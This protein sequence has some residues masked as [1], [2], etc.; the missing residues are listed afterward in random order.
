MNL[1][2]PLE[3]LNLQETSEDKVLTFE[4]S[5]FDDYLGQHEI[6][7]KLKVYTKAC[8]DRSDTLDHVLLFGPPGLGKTTLAKV[9]AKELSVSFKITSAPILERSG[10][11]VA[12]LS[13]L[14]AKEVLFID[15]IHR[16]PKNVEEILYSAMEN[17]C[18]DMIIGQGAGAKSIRLP[19]QPFT[20]IG[21]TTKTSLISG[22]LQTRFGI[23][24]RLDFYE[25]ED[26]AQIVIQNANFFKIPILPEAALSIGR[27][28]RGTPRIVKR[29]LRRV[30]DFAQVHNHKIIDNQIVDL[31][32][33]FLGIDED[34]LNK[35][36]RQILTHIIK[37]FDGGP[38]GVETLAALTGEDKETLEDV[39]EPF[40][41]RQGLL[42]K[43]SRGRQISPKKFLYLKRKLLGEK[44]D[45]QI[46]IF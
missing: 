32:L 1:E 17:F 41:I 39:C 40:L 44:T 18:V 27:R 4:P 19:L 5:C 22:P 29:I 16:L 43:T 28:A 45:G 10:D 24:E 2:M 8:K 23:V 46:N 26:L 9:V 30:R 7:E 37:D 11:L 31:A 42:I 20:L 15:E 14:Q 36:D 38:V 12:I 3:L 21:A 33:K 25:P 34:G 6:K 13:N 35:L